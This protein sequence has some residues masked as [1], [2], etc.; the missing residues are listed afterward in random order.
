MLHSPRIPIVLVYLRV[1]CTLYS[2]SVTLCRLKYLL[3]ALLTFNSVCERAFSPHMQV[4]SEL[5]SFDF[6]Y[7]SVYDT[8]CMS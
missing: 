1:Y 6:L 7:M 3:D 8:P 2:V 4:L 5:L